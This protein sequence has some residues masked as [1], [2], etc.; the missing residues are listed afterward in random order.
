MIFE[1]VDM[2]RYNLVNRFLLIVLLLWPYSTFASSIVFHQGDAEVWHPRQRISG[3]LSDLSAA[4]IKIYNG[5]SSFIVPVKNGEFVFHVLLQEGENLIRAV[6]GSGLVVVISDT[7]RLTLMYKP[8]PVAK[9]SAEV[10]GNRVT[11]TA[12]VIENTYGQKLQYHWSAGEQNPS[13]SRII[14]STSARA[15]AEI[16]MAYGKFYF[17]LTVIS[18]SDSC[19]F[20]TYVTRDRSGLRS[21]SIDR[22]H[23]D[24]IDSAVVYEVTPY[25]FVRDGTFDDIRHKLPELKML[26]INTLWL[27]PVSQSHQRGQGYDVVDYLAVRT[28]LGT[29]A[30]LRRLIEA[31]K[32]LNLRVIFDVVPNH[33]SIHHPYAKACAELGRQSHYYDFYQHAFDGA[34][35]AS[36]YHKHEKGFVYYFWKDLVN[37]NY[38]NEE[39]QRWMIEICKY[40]VREFGIDGYRFDAV[41]GVNSRMPSFGRRLRTALKSINPDILLL[42]E[43]KGADASVYDKGFDAAYDWTADTTWVSQWPWQYEYNDRE[44]HTVFNHPDVK[45]RAAMLSDAIF[46]NGDPSHPRLR[47]MENNDLPRFISH[48][49]LA[50]T[51]MAAGL[52]FSLPG[53]PMLYNGQEVGFAVHPY[54]RGEI[55]QREQSIR[56]TDTTGLFDHY[57]K[58]ISL[59]R[60]YASLRSDHIAEA[61]ISTDD[62]VVA[63]RR[64][65]DRE[66]MF[67]IVNMS[68]VP[69]TVKLDAFLAG[70]LL[71]KGPVK[72]VLTGVEFDPGSRDDVG[73][74]VMDGYSVRWLLVD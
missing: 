49:N 73:T 18:G 15:T 38:G 74:I 65:H 2:P 29:P 1:C 61:Y 56:A 31:A 34:P 11:L 69:A 41:W 30:Q 21:F 16:P 42:A 57:R 71:K 58:L 19:R 13:T 35:Y 8:L 28:D 27:Q 47:F 10:R 44:S 72:D 12:V 70:D 43:D 36:F 54:S 63:F 62:A 50:Q 17:N 68:S 32:A 55:F 26:G 3:S 7:L 9:P 59:R 4:N 39:V 25:K 67:V 23:S 46:K 60:Q 51:K 14:R 24:W 53:I 40:W 48:H 52:L 66:N 33:T 5:A 64:W 6:A 20:Q 22:D 45:K 37:L